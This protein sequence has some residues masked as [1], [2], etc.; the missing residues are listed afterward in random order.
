[1][2]D[3]PSNGGHCHGAAAEL[4]GDLG[5]EVIKVERPGAGDDTRSWGPP[6]L[7]DDDGNDTT[8]SAYCLSANRRCAPGPCARG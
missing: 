5:A 4:L 3:T 1:M 6:F 8:E 2:H 7:K